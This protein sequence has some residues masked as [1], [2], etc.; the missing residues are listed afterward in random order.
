MPEARIRRSLWLRALPE[1]DLR[2]GERVLT[3]GM[4]EQTGVTTAL[5]AAGAS[6]AVADWRCSA[7][8]AATAAGLPAE[9]ALPW[10]GGDEAPAGLGPVDVVLCDLGCLP[11]REAFLLAARFAARRLRPGGRLLVR[12]GNAEGVGG[13]ASRLRE[14]FGAAVPLAWGG[15]GRILACRPEGAAPALPAPAEPTRT[16]LGGVAVA[17]VRAPAVFNGGLPDDATQLLATV[18]AADR[19]A[20]RS[21]PDTA[22]DVGCGGGA[23]GLALLGLGARVCT[24]VDDSRIAVRAAAAN[25]T[26]NGARGRAHPVAADARAGLAGGPFDLVVCNPPFHAGPHE[27]RELGSAVARAAW[28]ATGKRLYVVAPRFLRLERA[29]PTLQEVAADAAFRVLRAVRGPS[30]RRPRPSQDGAPPS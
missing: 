7:L 2:S 26:L 14:W 16:L 20:W 23:L 25:A 4:A 18:V 5:G 6:V 27:D 21:P 30:R 9:R 29:V 28:E 13:A 19:E 11:G 24:L 12:G 17:L 10:D 1:L 22:C 3:L 15:R 8:H